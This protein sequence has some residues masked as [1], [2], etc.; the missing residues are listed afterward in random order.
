MASV[1]EVHSCPPAQSPETE[2]QIMP[3]GSEIVDAGIDGEAVEIHRP[4]VVVVG[5]GPT[6]HE[7]EH[8]ASSGHAQ[9][10]NL[11]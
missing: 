4:N 3:V 2:L 8:H 5:R 9:Q 10:S 11:V 7:V 1:G 6:K